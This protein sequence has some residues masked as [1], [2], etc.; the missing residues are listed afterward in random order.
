[1]IFNFF[2]TLNVFFYF[3]IQISFF[4][5][6]PQN[7]IFLATKVI[8]SLK[9]RKRILTTKKFQKWPYLHVILYFGYQRYPKKNLNLNMFCIRLGTK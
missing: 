5:G 3:S 8:F 1:M 9:C 7:F 4:L 2:L 6:K